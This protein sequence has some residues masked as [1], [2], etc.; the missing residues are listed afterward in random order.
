MN[1]RSRKEHLEAVAQEQR[2]MIF[3]EAPHKLRK[4]LSDFSRLL[5]RTGP[6]PCAGS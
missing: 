3:Y 6:S 1:K 2:T 5:G 4:T